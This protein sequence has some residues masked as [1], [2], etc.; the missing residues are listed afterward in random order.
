VLLQIGITVVRRSPVLYFS[1]MLL[2]ACSTISRAVTLNGFVLDETSIPVEQI[3]KGGPPRDG[4]PAIDSPRFVAK[5]KAGFLKDTERVLGIVINGEAKAYPIKILDWHEVVNDSIGS[6]SFVISYCPLCG[7]GM[8][9]NANEGDVILKF[10]VSGLLYQ[11]DVL[12]YDRNT[13]SL[14]SQVMGRS[15]S[16]KLNGKTL[17][18][19]PMAHTT[20]KDWRQRYP[21]TRVLTTETG[22]RRDYSRSPYLGYEHSPRLYFGVSNEAPD[23]Y[24]PKEL[25]MGLEM[26]GH[27]KA[28][29]FVELSKK[30]LSH[31][32]DNFNDTP[33]TVVWNEEARS[34]YITDAEGN[35][36]VTT[37][38]YWFAWYTFHPQTA[39]YSPP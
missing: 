31:F 35:E 2:L 8:A 30:A 38:A 12:L 33:I 4:I 10:G 11:S 7:T 39:I 25:V 19:L 32:N 36:L 17:R 15:I 16:G 14:W 6:R 27:F 20:W 28:Y 13:E 26:D 3:V 18:Q 22:Y 24:H 21:K 9:F 29:P 5:N 34:A 23:R 1:G 37:I